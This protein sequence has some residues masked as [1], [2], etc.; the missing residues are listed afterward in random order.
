MLYQGVS[1]FKTCRPWLHLIRGGLLLIAI[2]LWSYGIKTAPM[3]TATLMSFT[4]PI[5]VLLLAPIFLPERVTWLMWM[6]TCI[7]FGGI[8]IILQPEKTSLGHAHL[9]FVCATLAFSLLD[10]INKKYVTQEPML[11]M[12]FYATMVATIFLA[13]PALYLTHIPTKHDLKWLGILGVGSNLIL[14][15]LLK[16]FSLASASSLA[17]FR[18]LELLMSIGVC[19]VLFQEPPTSYSYLGAALII[20]ST[21]LI[22]YTQHSNTE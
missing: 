10:I 14:Y 7:G 15:F 21:L 17:P 13:F 16:A 3:I 1:S 5:F 12:L 19:Y 6:A 18:Y 8:A 20:P 9:S 4:V 2:S 11:G 22:V